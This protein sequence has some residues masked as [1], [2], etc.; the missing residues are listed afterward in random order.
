MRGDVLTLTEQRHVRTA[1]RHLRVRLG[2]WE[3]VGAALGFSGK[4]LRKMGTGE[5]PVTV[6]VAFTLARFLDSS[7]DGLLAG[8]AVPSGTCA[9][10]GHA[11]DFTDED[12]SPGRAPSDPAL[13][14]VK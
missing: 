11:P 7:I 2:T 8:Q 10:C 4:S 14:L 13:K 3:T 12:T 6:R 5:K 1:L 9:H